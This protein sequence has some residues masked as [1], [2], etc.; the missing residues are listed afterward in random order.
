[1]SGLGT[2]YDL[3]VTTYSPEGKLFQIDYAGKAV[4]QTGTTV[5]IAC[6]NGV[7]VGVEN[8]I[9]SELL[10]KSCAKRVFRISENAGV[11]VAGWL[12][13]ARKLVEKARSEC[14][15]YKDL[16]GIVIP[17]SQINDRVSSFVHKNT[18]YSWVR[19]YGVSTLIGSY[20]NKQPALH[21]ID[22]SGTSW[23][24]H[25]VAVGKESQAAKNELTKLKFEELDMRQAVREIARVLHQVHNSQKDKHYFLELGWVGEYTNGQFETVPEDLREEAF[26]YAEARNKTQDTQDAEDDEEDEDLDTMEA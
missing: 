5:G 14:K 17:P 24:Y 7:V 21:M 15:Q 9:K 13:D 19:P 11:A 22:P 26:Q 3:S 4:E 8:I 20:H 18:I 6:K 12:P 25:A 16:Y 23:E 1:M 10:I 2:G